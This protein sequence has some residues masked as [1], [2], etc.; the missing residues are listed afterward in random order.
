MAFELED[1]EGTSYYFAAR[2]ICSSSPSSLLDRYWVDM[3]SKRAFLYDQL[4]ES[5]SLLAEYRRKSVAVEATA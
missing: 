1:I 3:K 2:G 5:Y 4:K